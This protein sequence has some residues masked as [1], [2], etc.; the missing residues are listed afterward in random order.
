MEVEGPDDNAWWWWFA[1]LCLAKVKVVWSSFC[2]VCCLMWLSKNSSCVC[3]L[4][5]GG[6]L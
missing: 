6:G 4:A 1:G 2:D 5:L 3:S